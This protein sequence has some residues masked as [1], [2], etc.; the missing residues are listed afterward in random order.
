MSEKIKTQHLSP[1]GLTFTDIAQAL[2]SRPPELIPAEE[3]AL[4]S[5]ALI[6]REG[7]AGL[8]VLFIERAA[9]DGDPWSGDLGFPGGRVAEGERDPRLTA[10]RE[11]REEVGLDLSRGRFLGRLS[12]VVGAHLPI[13][14]S[15]FVYGIEGTETLSP[16]D[17]VHDVFWVPLAVLRDPAR[18]VN[19][20]VRFDG[21]GFERPAI[22]LP[23]KGKPVLWGLT[24]RL[25]MEFLE[26][27]GKGETN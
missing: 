23:A 16:D 22:L 5:V 26:M 27:T 1:P 15:C 14:V 10:E 17:E 19:A 8:E 24:Y 3:H 7:P 12:D 4:A 25:V 20:K 13:K 11:T 6:L 18:H 21:A 2:A 9:R